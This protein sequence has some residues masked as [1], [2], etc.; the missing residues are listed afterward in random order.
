MSDI[1]AE[2]EYLQLVLHNDDDTPLDFI[3][4]LIRS[5]FSQRL[6]EARAVTATIETQGKAV[7]GT[8]PRAVAEAL[9]HAARQRIRAS[10][11]SLLMTAEAGDDIAIRLCKLCSDFAGE[12]EIRI[13]GKNMPICDVCMLAVAHNVGDVLEEKQFRYASDVLEWHFAGIPQDQL[14]AT[15]R[16]FPGHMRADVQAAVDR[17][18]SASPIRFFGIH[19]RQRYETLTIAA[20][21]LYSDSAHGI[22]PAQ[23][24]DVDIGENEPVKCLTT[25][26][27][28]ALRTICAMRFCCRPIANTAKRPGFASRSWSPAA[29]PARNS[30]NAV[31]RNWKTRSAPRGPIAARSCRSMPTPVIGEDR[32]G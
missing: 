20:L 31:S 24:H 27:G 28:S 30:S 16:Q 8:Y 18:F 7:C 6:A 4:T 10:G 29:S 15:S 9:L 32:R 3:V 1:S 11:H 2:A 26:C 17:L 5:L 25:V 22:A 14:V 21:T 13:A 23:Y 12:N 19:E